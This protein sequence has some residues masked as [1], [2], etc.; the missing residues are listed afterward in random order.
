MIS[1]VS[2]LSKHSEIIKHLTLLYPNL[3][4]R[5][6]I[7]LMPP[8][9]E[10]VFGTLSKCSISQYCSPFCYRTS[11]IVAKVIALN[12]FA[13]FLYRVCRMFNCSQLF[14]CIA[15]HSYRSQNYCDS[16][17]VS[18]FFALKRDSEKYRKS[19]AIATQSKK[20]R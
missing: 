5:V 2:I 7:L 12:L 16:N 11:N 18:N 4:F 20:Q 1:I 14:F 9:C 10:I 8:K 17:S 19:F 6:K 3:D 15:S 13:L